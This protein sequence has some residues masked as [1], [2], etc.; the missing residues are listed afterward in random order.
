MDETERTFIEKLIQTHRSHLQVLEQQATTLGIMAPPHIVTQIAENQQKI[1]ELE[2]RLRP[3]SS[4]RTD[5]PR[6]NLPPRDYERFIGRQKE[7]AE[8]RRLH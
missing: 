1:A 3:P 8:L 2:T 5:G 6:H 7:L 4:R